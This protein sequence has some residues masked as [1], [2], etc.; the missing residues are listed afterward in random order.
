MR[1]LSHAKYSVRREQIASAACRS[2]AVPQCV[3]HLAALYRVLSVRFPESNAE[4]GPLAEVSVT[5][6]RD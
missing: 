2:V 3:T 4:S 5:G 6:W 1:L